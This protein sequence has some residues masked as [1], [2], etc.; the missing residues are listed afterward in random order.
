MSFFFPVCG[1]ES[2]K[3]DPFTFLSL[4]LPME[5]SIHL[6]AIVI[7]QDGSVPVKYGLTLDM[8][9]RYSDIKPALSRLSRIPAESLILVEIVQSQF[10]ISTA[11]E[12]Q[13]LKGLSGSCLFAYEFQPLK[14]FQRPS[15]SSTSKAPQ[16]LSEIQRGTVARKHFV[17]LMG[18]GH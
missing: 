5:S 9:A 4:P 7:K 11:S 17:K 3:F 10:R 12:E 15:Q 14:G 13:K 8:E 6:E 16:T 18:F 1:H 2:V